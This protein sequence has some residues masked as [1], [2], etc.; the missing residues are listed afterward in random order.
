[1]APVILDAPGMLGAPDKP[2][3]YMSSGAQ[4][5]CES[6]VVRLADAGDGKNR[7]IN[8]LLFQGIYV[9]SSTEFVNVRVAM[10]VEWQRTASHR[11][12]LRVHQSRWNHQPLSE[13][14]PRV[15]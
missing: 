7:S 12:P 10:Q 11:I 15:M 1:M 3:A 8:P 2:R 5:R 9:C 4:W 14:S 6:R 13:K